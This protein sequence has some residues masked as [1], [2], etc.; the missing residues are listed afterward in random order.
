METL[1]NDDTVVVIYA[2]EHSP[3]DVSRR[4]PARA[5]HAHCEETNIKT[6]LQQLWVILLR[7]EETVSASV[8]TASAESSCCY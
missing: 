8:Q 7:Q 5:L 2:V 4:V 6:Q 1:A 3:N